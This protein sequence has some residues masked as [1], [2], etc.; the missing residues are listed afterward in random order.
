MATWGNKKKLTVIN[1]DTHED[2]LKNYQPRNTNSPR[3]LEDYISQVSEETEGIVTNKL[4]QEFSRT[5]SHILGAL[6]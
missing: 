6:S 1:G 2:H 5:E 3:I 4:S